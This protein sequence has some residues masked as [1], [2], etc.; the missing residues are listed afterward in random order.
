MNDSWKTY[1]LLTA[2]CFFLFWAVTSVYLTVI[3]CE[4]LWAAHSLAM[5]W[6][7]SLT[8]YHKCFWFCDIAKH[9]LFSLLWL[10]SAFNSVMT[11]LHSSLTKDR[12]LAEL[13]ATHR[14]QK[15]A[16]EVGQAACCSAKGI[17]AYNIISVRLSHWRRHNSINGSL[18]FSCGWRKVN[19]TLYS[20]R[21]KICE[22]IF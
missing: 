1:C 11:I 3:V 10:L 16:L 17:S 5:L 9:L 18:F 2:W 20:N 7:K 13:R 19:E 4:S 6:G 8:H 21:L 22:V 12:W 14:I 15:T